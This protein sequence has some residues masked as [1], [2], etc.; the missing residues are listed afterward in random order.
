M[1]ILDTVKA[2]GRHRRLT[3]LQ[4]MEKVGRLEREA[5]NRT[6]QLVGLATEV[7]GLKAERS[8]LEAQLDTAGIE[9][10]GAREDLAAAEEELTA[11]RAFKANVTS[12]SDL[13]AQDGPIAPAPTAERFDTGPV[14]RAGKRPVPTWA[15]DSETTQSIPVIDLPQQRRAS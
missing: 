4:L 7:D 14:L 13:S 9:L 1:S 12:V 10:S 8:Q 3:R 11:L 15:G 2:H 5:D 6:C